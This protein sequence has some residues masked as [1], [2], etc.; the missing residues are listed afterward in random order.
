MPLNIKDTEESGQS[1]S[2]KVGPPVHK[3]KTDMSGGTKMAITIVVIAIMGVGIFMMYK[4][5]MFGSKHESQPQ[6]VSMQPVDT[7]AM[8]ASPDTMLAA[9]QTE[10]P[11]AQVIEEPKKEQQMASKT[12]EPKS[13]PKSKAKH[14]A[15]PEKKREI[16]TEPKHEVAMPV[17][18]PAGSGNYTIYAGSYTSK[19]T[20]NEEA[21]R[22]NEAGYQAF[23]NESS[24]KK[25]TMYRVCVGRYPT[26]DQ[27]KQQAEKLKDA[28]ESGYWVDVIK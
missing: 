9:Q 11:P 2:S 8:T 28:F 6:Q 19:N 14:E 10:T 13:K 12:E 24:G 18:Q 15:A 21:G 3:P 26:K 22:W 7:T 27:A 17:K 23:V 25:G 20:A 4:A 16:K 1:G 5:G